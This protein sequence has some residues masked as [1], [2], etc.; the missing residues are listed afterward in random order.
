MKHNPSFLYFYFQIADVLLLGC[1]ELLVAIVSDDPSTRLANGLGTFG[2][3]TSRC[4]KRGDLP[5]FW[6]LRCSHVQSVHRFRGKSKQF[7]K[8]KI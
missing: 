5:V 2:D 3:L 4:Q 7:R 6:R 8:V 1:F